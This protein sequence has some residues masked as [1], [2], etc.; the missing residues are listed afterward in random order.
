MYTIYYSFFFF[1]IV[2]I[3]DFR[4]LADLHAL[5]SG[6]SKKHYGWGTLVILQISDSRFLADL[7]DLES[8]ESKKHYVC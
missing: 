2:Q 8:G 5:G 6:K 4:F 7:Q 3:F 1:V